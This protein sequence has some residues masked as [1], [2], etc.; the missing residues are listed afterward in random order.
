MIFHGPFCLLDDPDRQKLA[1]ML[2][3]NAINKIDAL[4]YADIINYVKLPHLAYQTRE[5]IKKLYKQ[6]M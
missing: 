6:R 1:E 4:E 5:H 2:E 3:A